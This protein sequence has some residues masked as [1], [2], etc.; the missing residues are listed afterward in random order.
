MSELQRVLP[1]SRSLL[2]L[3]LALGEGQ[4]HGYAV[5]K[6]VEELSGGIVKMGPGTLYT[7]I[8][9]GE[10]QGLLRESADRPAEADQSQRRYYELTDFGREALAAE[11]ERIGHFVDVARAALSGA[12]AK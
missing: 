3:L 10:E 4:R 8:Q 5:K 2:H 6:R 7:T 12:S 1:L 11:V 9:R